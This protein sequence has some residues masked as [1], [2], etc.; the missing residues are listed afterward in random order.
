MTYKYITLILVLAFAL[1]LTACD[2]RVEIYKH[3]HPI[4]SN[5]QVP[6]FQVDWIDRDG[7]CAIYGDTNSNAHLRL[8]VNRFYDQRGHADG[9]G[10]FTLYFKLDSGL[11]TV[12]V[13]SSYKGIDAEYMLVVRNP[14]HK[15]RRR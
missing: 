4:S 15:H 8:Y 13:V 3:D 7:N 10:R 6:V 1:S 5:T 9:L 14:Y 12:K 2:G 11:N